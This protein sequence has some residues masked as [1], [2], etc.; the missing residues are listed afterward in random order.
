M[1]RKWSTILIAVL[2]VLV[3]VACATPTVPPPTSAPP[4]TS[5]PVVSS[6]SQA[7]TAPPATTAPASTAAPLPHP[8]DHMNIAWVAITGNQAPAWIAKEGNIFPKYGLDVSLSFIQGSS[9][10]TASMVGGSTDIAQMAAPSAITAASQGA[11]VV[12]IAGFLNTSVFKLMGDPSI[13]SMSDLKGKTIAITKFGSSDEFILKRILKDN[14]LDPT[15]DVK[16]TQSGDASG[17]LA[18]FKSKLCD[19]ILLSPPNDIVAQKQGAAM[20]LDTIPLKIPYQA[21]GLATTHKYIQTHRA[22]ALNFIRAE[23][24]ALQRFKNDRAFAESV[25]GKYLQT[26]DPDVLDGS[27][28]AYSKAFV[29]IPY[30]SLPG[31]QEILDES[32]VTGKKP[33]D[34]VDTSL[35]K[36]LEDTGFFKAAPAPMTPLPT[37][38][39]APT[40]TP[41]KAS[42]TATAKP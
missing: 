11:D 30:P 29:D 36:E 23:T 28:E 26:N 35:V 39:P 32:K 17:Q 19:A 33:E 10:A 37:L 1:F 42:A 31:I 3:A 16:I 5:A 27:W 6:A 38:P 21:V 4:A 13:K 14:G 18:Q 9:T 2:L 40:A 15:K 8:L 41:A 34:F 22:D 12:L 24:E 7:T 20:I 25:M